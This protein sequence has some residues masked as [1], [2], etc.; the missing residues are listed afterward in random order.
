MGAG[1]GN[2]PF[3]SYAAVIAQIVAAGASAVRRLEP[4]EY[5]PDENVAAH[6]TSE[7]RSLY[8]AVKRDLAPGESMAR[9]PELD[10]VEQPTTAGR[11]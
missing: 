8:N 10:G 7:L 11:C 1:K 6:T 3:P 2:S 5:A 9:S 4:V